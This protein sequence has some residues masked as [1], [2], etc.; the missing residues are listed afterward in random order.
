MK[1]ESQDPSM[2]S[3]IDWI[4][5]SNQWEAFVQ[6]N[7]FPKKLLEQASKAKFVLVSPVGDVLIPDEYQEEQQHIWHIELHLDTC[8][9]STLLD[10][11]IAFNDFVQENWESRNY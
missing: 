4:E 11:E 5:S 9:Y 6:T 10:I 8:N 3:I 7:A 1:I 2:Y